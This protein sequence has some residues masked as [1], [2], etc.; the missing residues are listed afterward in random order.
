MTSDAELHEDAMPNLF[1]FASPAGWA[2]LFD[3]RAAIVSAV[4][5]T[6]L[7]L[8]R[9]CFFCVCKSSHVFTTDGN[10]AHGDGQHLI[11]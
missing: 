10:M 1:K 5:V 3:V 7:V 2:L 6:F 8:A 11:Y 4:L 9:Q